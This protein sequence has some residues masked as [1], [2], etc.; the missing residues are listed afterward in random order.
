MKI[1]LSE[2]LIAWLTLLS[3]LSISAVA[4]YYSVAGL[5]SI[6]AAAAVP[7]MVMG[8]ALEVSKLIATV[9]L[10]INW[11]QAPRLIKIYLMSAI[12]VLMLITSMGIF[13]YL[14]KAHLDQAVP[15]GDISAK[16]ELID[17]K[18]Q[19]QKDNIASAKAALKQ[20]DAQVNEMLSRSTDNKGTER[21]VQIRKQQEKERAK[22][23]KDIEIGNANI[24][25]LNEERA[26][27]AKDLRKVE[28]EVGP[29][30]YIAALLYGDNPDGNLLE[31]AV[32][33]VIITIVLVFDPLAV[34]LLLASQYS[35]QWFR[36]R[37][38]SSDETKETVEQPK[39]EPVPEDDGFKFLA[40]EKDLYPEEPAKES[41]PEIMPI[42]QVKDE[43]KP[44][45]A[46][47]LTP[48]DQWNQMVAEA[49]AAAMVK[50]VEE[51]DDD[52]DPE[53]TDEIKQ[54]KAVWK[55]TN[56][57]TSVKLERKLF[58]EGKIDVLPWMVPPYLVEQTPEQEGYK[59]IP[60][61]E[62]INQERYKP[63]LTEVIEPEAPKSN[64]LSDMIR[65]N[66]LKKKDL[67]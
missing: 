64:R 43:P 12:T 13:G 38:E 60:E 40:E 66:D 67:S 16:V 65:N 28:A 39:E 6:F 52:E 22:L 48:L 37:L 31:K 17:T 56:P 58:N 4:V 9:W 33:W 29:I 21:A 14:S 34:I 46:D 47:S 23:Q 2:K 15:T 51:H 19:T 49:E 26:P 3:G 5:V 18:I 41:E 50:P 11:K 8:I 42:E 57:H 54:A 36:E 53:D 10:K 59:I 25:K 24:A 32:R 35:F 20:M 55:E 63:N 7:I 27:V 62:Q 61:L 44:A 45:T 1:S 30:K